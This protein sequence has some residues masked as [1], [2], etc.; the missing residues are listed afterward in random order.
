[1]K[2]TYNY[3]LF[4]CFLALFSCGPEKTSD[5]L[6]TPDSIKAVLKNAPED[7]LCGVGN[8]KAEA[9][10]E[11]ILLAEDRAREQIARALSTSVMGKFDGDDQLQVDYSEART[12]THV[13]NSKVIL[14]EKDKNGNWWCVVW[15]PTDQNEPRKP[16]MPDDVIDIMRIN[17]TELSDMELKRDFIR[18]GEIITAFQKE[19]SIPDWVFYSGSLPEDMA[20]GLGAAKLDN[21]KAALQLAKERARRSLAHSLDTE[22]TSVW[23]TF[24]SAFTRHYEE[25]NTSSTSIYDYI[26]VPT[27]LWEYAKSK[28]GTWWVLLSCPVQSRMSDAALKKAFELLE[29][30]T[31]QIE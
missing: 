10:G 19:T 31:L 24:E 21:D 16:V 28:D 14:R 9:D 12:I 25:I 20:F 30:Q 23:Y 15:A 8:A 13:Y 5:T 17:A 26:A 2:H 1:M 29:K 6:E 3:L 11:A 7:V 27:Y 4:F 18:N 22:V